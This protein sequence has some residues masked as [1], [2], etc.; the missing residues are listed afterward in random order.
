MLSVVDANPDPSVD[1]T[2]YLVLGPSARGTQTGCPFVTVGELGSGTTASLPSRLW[3]LPKKLKCFGPNN[4]V[5]IVRAFS[6][7]HGRIQ[8]RGSVLTE[9]QEIGA[10]SVVTEKLSRPSHRPLH[11]HLYY[12][13][14]R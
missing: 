9:A 3:C 14:F 5:K 8:S 4:K 10:S 13:L 6:V 7:A 11:S 2:P 12:H 1:F